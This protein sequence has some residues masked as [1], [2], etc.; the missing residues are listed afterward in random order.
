MRA[1]YETTQGRRVMLRLACLTWHLSTPCSAS[2]H[3]THANSRCSAALPSLYTTFSIDRMSE[4]NFVQLL[5]KRA[6]IISAD[7]CACIIPISSYTS[8]T[9]LYGACHAPVDLKCGPSTNMRVPFSAFCVHNYNLRCA[10]SCMYASS[11]AMERPV[12]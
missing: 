6:F 7:A 12:V 3:S 1:K 9:C 4:V 5:T 2:R 10:L 11:A 8:S